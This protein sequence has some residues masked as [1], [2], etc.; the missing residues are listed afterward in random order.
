MSLTS[1]GEVRQREEQGEGSMLEEG[2][3]AGTA[4]REG[5]QSS[6]DCTVCGRGGS[7]RGAAGRVGTAPTASTPSGV[8]PVY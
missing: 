4:G 6:F 2:D 1:T 7:Q 8:P 3:G 5:S